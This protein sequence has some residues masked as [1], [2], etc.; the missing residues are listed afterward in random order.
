MT[1]VT[2]CPDCGGSTRHEW[3]ENVWNSYVE[4]IR[5]CDA[6]NLQ[7]TVTYAW[8][9]IEDIQRFDDADGDESPADEN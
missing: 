6:C 4:H 2:S 5:V 9:E 3:T 7:Y 8:P 1:N